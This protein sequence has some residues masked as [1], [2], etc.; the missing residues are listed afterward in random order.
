MVA[1]RTRRISEAKAA[2][3]VQWDADTGGNHYGDRLKGKAG[4]ERPIP[5]N[6]GKSLAARF[7]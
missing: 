4:S 6:S 1:N 3:K 7:H 2:A 5:M